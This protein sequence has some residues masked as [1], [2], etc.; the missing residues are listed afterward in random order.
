MLLGSYS[1][2]LSLQRRIAIPKKFRRQL[3]G[4]LIIAKWYEGCLI[5]VGQTSWEALLN[6]LTGEEKT[7]TAPVRDTDR[8]ILGS[9]YEIEPD[10][11]GRV[12]IPASLASY[13]TLKKDIVFIGLGDRVEIWEREGWQQR[14]KFVG[15]HAGE[16]IE[17][18]ANEKK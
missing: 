1:G 6:R 7:I 15:A 10:G 5:V 12:V 14:E 3:G 2:I 9:A 16:F 4:K 18:L 8:F 17:K 13:A 11:Q